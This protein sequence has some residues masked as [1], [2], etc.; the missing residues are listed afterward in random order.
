MYSPK[1]V[2]IQTFIE[3]LQATYQSEFGDRRPH[4]LNFLKAAAQMALE[5]IAN[6]DA[7]YHDLE[8][9]ILVTAVG[10][11][12]LCAKR[13]VDGATSVSPGDWLHMI[14]GLL[15]H[16]IGYVK[17]ICH[18]DSPAANQYVTAIGN[19]QVTLDDG[20]TDAAL[21]PFHVDRGK[22]FVA[23]RF[24]A[25]PLIQ[26]KQLQALIEFTRFPVPAG[27]TYQ[28]TL[29]YPGLARAAD[30]I[31][32]LSDRHYL[33]KLPGLFHEM[34]ETGA[35]Q[36]LGYQHPGDVRAGFPGFYWNVVHPYIKDAIDYLNCTQAGKQIIASLQANVFT[37]EHEPQPLTPVSPLVSIQPSDPD[38]LPL[39]TLNAFEMN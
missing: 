22:Q 30:L 10:Q 35:H 25:E 39:L 14:T 31:G 11:E 8:H 4:H 37:I 18:G 15:C 23:E 24:A 5:T 9:T 7:L 32:Q 20:A 2:L 6:S 34:K 1:H 36:K 17:G 13:I 26:V 16:D 28:A 19:D 29:S 12:I 38:A 21:T 33:Q 3:N 27:A